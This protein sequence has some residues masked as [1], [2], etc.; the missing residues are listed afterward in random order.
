MA[1]KL[2]APVL[3]ETIARVLR[4]ERRR[5]RN[6]AFVRTAAVLALA[7]ALV[8]VWRVVNRVEG[9]QPLPL[10][11]A[12]AI[13]LALFAELLTVEGPIKLLP[14]VPHEGGRPQETAKPT[15]AAPHRESENGDEPTP[16][17]SA[18]TE[19][20]PFAAPPPDQKPPPGDVTVT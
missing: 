16:P 20:D 15:P 5:R 6:A 19:P 11:L 10:G 1:E 2:A 8:A 3:D 14:G 7:T 13:V 17:Q 18:G 4:R 12:A 9:T